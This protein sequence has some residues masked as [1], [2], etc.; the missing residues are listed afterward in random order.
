MYY[1]VGHCMYRGIILVDPVDSTV[2]NPVMGR[3][4]IDRERPLSGSFFA[5]NDHLAE[6][7]HEAVEKANRVRTEAIS[8]SWKKY[9]DLLNTKIFTILDVPNTHPE[10][11]PED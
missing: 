2:V 11:D 10:P 3:E 1:Y 4:V 8:R 6:T 5:L 9:H 7:V